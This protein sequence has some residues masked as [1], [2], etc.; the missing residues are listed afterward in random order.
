MTIMQQN[1]IF[2]VSQPI[3]FRWRSCSCLTW[4]CCATTIGRT[5][6]RSS[7]CRS[8]RW[9][10]VIIIIIITIMSSAF[11][12]L[13]SLHMQLFYPNWCN[14]SSTKTLNLGS[15]SDQMW[16][17]KKGIFDGISKVWILCQRYHNFTF[18]PF[19]CQLVLSSTI[20]I[21]ITQ[22]SLN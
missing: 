14:S 2:L 22:F 21:T 18:V 1:L 16:A 7:R 12:L 9:A 20:K 15:N 5:G 3:V 10:H 4:L 19:K 17:P 6:G 8:G 11:L 13:L